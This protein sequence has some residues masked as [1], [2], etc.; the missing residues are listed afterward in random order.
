M[1]SLYLT[2]LQPCNQPAEWSNQFAGSELVCQLM[3]VETVSLVFPC[4]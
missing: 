2:S 1:A 4:E 3:S